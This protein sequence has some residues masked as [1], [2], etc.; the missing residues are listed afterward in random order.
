M[1]TRIVRW[2]Q[3]TNEKTNDLLRQF[4]R[5]DTRFNQV[6]RKEIKQVQ[7]MLN[8]RPRKV[9]NWHSPAQAFSQLVR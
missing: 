5:K 7:A 8:D 6:S 3:G 2:E 1:R 9:I 4:F